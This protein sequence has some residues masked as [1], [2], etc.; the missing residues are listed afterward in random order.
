MAQPTQPKKSESSVKLPI[1][2][3]SNP[4][5]IIPRRSESEYDILKVL[6]LPLNECLEFGM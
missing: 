3:A 2:A 6:W 4:F 5:L 1:V